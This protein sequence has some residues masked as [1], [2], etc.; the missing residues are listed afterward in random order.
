[1]LSFD[2]FQVLILI[3]V[4]GS[5]IP[6]FFL[7]LKCLSFWTFHMHV[8]V[9]MSLIGL[10]HTPI[11]KHF[12]HI[13]SLMENMT[14]LGLCEVMRGTFLDE[15]GNSEIVW[16]LISHHISSIKSI[17]FVYAEK[18]GLR[19]SKVYGG[20]NITAFN[21]NAVSVA[22]F[23]SFPLWIFFIKKNSVTAY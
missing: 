15:R 20:H 13:R 7:T 22:M 3:S 5:P 10:K 16:I 9:Y 1:M 19:H 17:Q 8:C 11:I 14:K 18:S 21:F 2:L 12:S 4:N 6:S 23:K